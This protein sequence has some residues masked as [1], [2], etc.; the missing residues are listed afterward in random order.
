MLIRTERRFWIGRPA[1]ARPKATKAE[2]RASQ[3]TNLP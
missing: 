2:T 1:G 3:R